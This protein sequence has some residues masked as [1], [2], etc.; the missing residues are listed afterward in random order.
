MQIK[1]KT[2]VV[3]DIV[4][5][6]GRVY[7]TIVHDMLYGPRPHAHGHTGT[8][9]EGVVYVNLGVPRTVQL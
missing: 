1:F 9:V 8:Y 4:L 5:F 3:C 6:N 7:S 2:K